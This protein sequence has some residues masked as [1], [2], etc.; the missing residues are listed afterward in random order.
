MLPTRFV[1]TEK[2]NE[3]GKIVRYKARIVVRGFIQGHIDRTFAPVVDFTSIR[4]CLTLAIQR[5]HYVHQFDIRTAFLHRD[6]DDDV[7]IFPPPEITLYNQVQVLKLRKGL[8]GLRQSPRLWHENFCDIMSRLKF[9][10]L[11][12]DAFIFHRENIYILLYVDDV[13]LFGPNREDIDQVK[14]QLANNLDVKYL[15]SLHYFLGVRFIRDSDGAWIAQ[16]SYIAQMLS[17]YG[18]K[19]CKAVKTPMTECTLEDLKNQTIL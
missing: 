10:Q 1:L 16:K 17:K 12:S 9:K 15:G 19:E 7:Y 3:H 4:T 2:R 13:I 5:S 18:M 14:K 8:Y 6:I 11:I